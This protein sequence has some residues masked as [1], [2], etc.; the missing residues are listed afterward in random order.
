MIYLVVLADAAESV[1]DTIGFEYCLASSSGWTK[2]PV[3]WAEIGESSLTGPE[4]VLDMT[5]KV[6]LIKEKLKAARDRQKSYADNRRK[7][8]E[9][10]VGDRVMLKVSPWK[11]VIR[12]GK[13][14]KLAPRYVGPFEILERVGPVAYRLRLPEELSGIKVDKTLRFVEEPVENSDREVKRLKCSRMVVVKAK[15]LAVR[16]LVKV[17]WNSKCNFELTWVW[18]DYLKDKFGNQSIERDRLIGIGFVLDFV[19][20]IS[21]TFGDKEMIL[22]F[23]RFSD[24]SMDWLSKRKFV[25]VCHEKVVR[26]P[27]EGDEILQVYSERTQGVVKTLNEHKVFKDKILATLSE[28]SKVENA[29]AEMLCKTNVVIDALRRKERVKPR[30]VRAMAMTIRYGVRGMML[31][32]QSEGSKSREHSSYVGNGEERSN[33]MWIME[34]KV[35]LLMSSHFGLRHCLRYWSDNEIDSPER[36]LISQIF[37]GQSNVT[38]S[39]VRAG[40]ILSTGY[41]LKRMDKCAPFEALY[42][43]KCRSPVLWAEIGKSSLIGPKLVQETTDKVVL[44]KENLKAA[45]DRQKSHANNRRKPLDFEIKFDKTLRFVEELV[46]NSG[47]EIKRLKCSRMVVVKLEFQGC[48]TFGVNIG[49]GRTIERDKYPRLI[50]WCLYAFM[51]IMWEIDSQSIECDHLNEIGMVLQSIRTRYVPLFAVLERDRLKTL[52]DLCHEKVVRISLEGDEIL[53]VQG[54][55]TQGVAKTLLNTKFRIDLVPGATPV[56]KSPYRLAPSEMQ[57]LS[58]QLQELQD[59]ANVLGGALSRK[60]GVKLRRVR[61]KILAVQSEAFKKKNVLAERLHG[62]DQQMERKGDESLYFIDQIWFLLVGSVMDKAHAS[63]YLVHPRADK[64][65]HNLRDIYCYHLSIRCAPFEALYERKCRSPVLWAEI[66]EGSLIG[67]ELVLE[68][69][70]K[71]V[72]IKE[73]LKAARDRQK[74]YVDFRRKPLEFE[75]GDRVLLKVTPWKGVVHFGKKDKLAPRYVGPFEILERMGLVAYRLRLPEEL[76]SVHDTFHVSNLKKCLADTNL[77]VPLDEIKV[78]KTLCF[79]EEPVE[80]MDR[81]VKRLKHRKIALVKVRWNSKRGPEFTWEHEDQMRIKYPQLFVDRVV[82]PTS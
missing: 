36:L 10:E 64:T 49:Y 72:L 4:L 5:D 17:S 22:W 44:I 80:I 65:Y 24:L 37:H 50:V 35:K 77:H 69:T 7:P 28:T 59:K 23:K 51:L 74:S 2:S 75:V 48:I 27:L 20:F 57:E 76:N 42:G 38:E 39:V 29:P 61:G 13:K 1:R 82:E 21:F 43:R 3:L 67:P 79:V 12:F 73:K 63:R 54:E 19:E 9:F 52:M 62:L 45:R 16:Y 34:F 55:R 15:W 47:R 31:A 8:L 11:G 14:G 60:E 40:W 6:V 41:F 56:A 68:M 70:D 66:G 18:E 33:G 46:E 32:A 53:R 26:I 71:V 81:E 25:I 30:R 58:E 78:D